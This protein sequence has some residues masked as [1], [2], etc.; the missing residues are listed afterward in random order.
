MKQYD[1]FFIRGISDYPQM[2]IEEEIEIF[3]KKVLTTEDRNRLLLS[4]V[5]LIVLIA[6]EY[7]YEGVSIK[8]LI[9]E[10]CAGLMEAI[11]KYDRN[12]IGKCKFMSYANH[13]IRKNIRNS[14]HGNRIGHSVKIPK[15]KLQTLKKIN[16]TIADFQ[17]KK[18]RIPTDKEISEL[19]GF[20]QR[21]IKNCSTVK[22]SNILSLEECRENGFFCDYEDVSFDKEHVDYTKKVLME[23]LNSLSDREKFI[24][25]RRFFGQ[26]T[27]E[28]VANQVGLSKERIRQIQ[29]KALAKLKNEMESAVI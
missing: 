10:G 3:S 24:I 16:K 28:Q 14:V 15:A 25:E 2:T 6:K 12:M 1:D 20:S 8:D 9:Q 13:W 4:N 27:L 17:S 7:N 19:T 21:T 23:K 18:N 29:N 11:D 26:E 22:N 5:K